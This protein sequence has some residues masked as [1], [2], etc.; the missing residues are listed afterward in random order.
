MPVNKPVASDDRSIT[1]PKADLR[2]HSTTWHGITLSDPFAWLR[3]DNW[4][5]VMREPDKL[6]P[7]IRAYLE[8]ENA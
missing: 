2:P 6:A 7:D 8:A 1:P 3:A 4:R 5:D